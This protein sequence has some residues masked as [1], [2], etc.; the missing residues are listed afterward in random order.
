MYVNGTVKIDVG[1]YLESI[2]AFT[3]IWCRRQKRLER[4]ST[5]RIHKAKKAKKKRHPESFSLLMM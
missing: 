2:R 3:P 4:L 1:V 5:C